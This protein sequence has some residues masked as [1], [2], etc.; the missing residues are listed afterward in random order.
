MKPARVLSVVCVLLLCVSGCDQINPGALNLD[1]SQFNWQTWAL[2]AL[3]YLANSKS[4]LSGLAKVLTQVL[5]Q[6]RI[7]PPADDSSSQRAEELAK[8]LAD[9]L[10]RLKGQ[11][12]LREQA[13]QFVTAVA[14]LDDEG[15]KD[16]AGK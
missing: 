4:H 12:Q 15:G 14:V 2:I 16:A 11:P 13:I 8:M 3:A 6:I 7:L 9:L 10:L 5:R 1:L